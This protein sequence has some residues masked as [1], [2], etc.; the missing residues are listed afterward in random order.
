MLGQPSYR[1]N[2]GLTSS[3]KRSAFEEPPII[4]QQLKGFHI[5]KRNTALIGNPGQAIDQPQD[6]LLLGSDTSTRL[7]SMSGLSCSS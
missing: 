1:T 4:A 2:I 6:R 5:L 3:R 7:I